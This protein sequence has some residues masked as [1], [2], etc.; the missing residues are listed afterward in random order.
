MKRP[1]ELALPGLL[2]FQSEAAGSTWEPALAG[3]VE[4]KAQLDRDEHRDGL[5]FKHARAETE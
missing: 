1:G 4:R 3:L 2:F 5:S